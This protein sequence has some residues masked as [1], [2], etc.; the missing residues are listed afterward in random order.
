MFLYSG[1]SN[2]MSVIFDVFVLTF[3]F[4]WLCRGKLKCAFAFTQGI[5]LVW[6]FVNVFY[7]RFF[8]H[9]LP[10]SAIASADG[11]TDSTTLAAMTD[12]FRFCDLF[13][14]I[15]PILF[16]FIYRSVKTIHI[17]QRQCLQLL[18]PPILSLFLTIGALSAYYFVQPRYRNNLL[19][20]SIHMKGVLYDVTCN[21]MP[22]LSHYQAGS[23]RVL[24]FETYGILMPRTL[25][26]EERLTIKRY[27][28]TP[29]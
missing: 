12:G 4:S 14:F 17:N 15:S 21:A 22:N 6:A 7:S 19:L 8:D 2:F 9:Y 13:F 26:N 25:T 20:Y 11:L 18:L 5:T 29:T 23:I 24:L 27:I 28:T 3:L 10:L 1:I 16:F